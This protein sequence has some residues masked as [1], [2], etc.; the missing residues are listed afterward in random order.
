[1]AT[2]NKKMLVRNLSVFLI[3]LLSTLYITEVSARDIDGVSLPDRVTL[4][5]TTTELQLN[6]MGYRT[7]FVFKIYVG[8]LY[9]ETKVNTR[10]AVQ[11][12][13]GPKRVVMHIVYDEVSREKMTKAWHEG[14][15]ENSSEQQLAKLQARLEAFVSY[16]PDLKAGDEVLLDYI[17]ASGTRVT[18]NGE[19]KGVIDG[20]DFYQALLDVWLG[21]E[22]ADAD[23]KD[24]MLGA[25]ED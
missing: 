17:P 20:A 5:D 1:M 25:A 12:L 22:P 4:K 11:A 7:K 9:T 15:E 21:D 23:L 18:I 14:F 8:A 6:G 3:I 2:K 13:T 24:A 19:E 10:D 16:F